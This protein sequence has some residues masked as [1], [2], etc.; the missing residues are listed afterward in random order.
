MRRCLRL[1]EEENEE[2]PDEQAAWKPDPGTHDGEDHVGSRS[3]NDSA[4]RVLAMPC[5]ECNIVTLE[6][7]NTAD[8]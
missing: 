5:L 7:R 2:G 1:I 8:L 4:Y 6:Y 3:S